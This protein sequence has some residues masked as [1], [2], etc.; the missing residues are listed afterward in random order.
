L[1]TAVANLAKAAAP[2]A[3]P[4]LAAPAEGPSFLNGWGA[5][6]AAICVSDLQYEDSDADECAKY[7]DISSD[8]DDNSDEN[9]NYWVT[10]PDGTVTPLTEHIVASDEATVAPAV[11]LVAQTYAEG[12]ESSLSDEESSDEEVVAQAQVQVPLPD[13]SSSDE[14]ADD[15]DYI[16]DQN[17][18]DAKLD[19]LDLQ[20][21]VKQGKRNMGTVELPL[22][23]CSDTGT[24]DVDNSFSMG[25]AEQGWKSLCSSDVFIVDT[26]AGEFV[27]P[28]KSDFVEGSLVDAV[29]QQMITAGNERHRVAQLGRMR[30]KCAV[31]GHMIDSKDQY[32][33]WVPTSKF[34]LGSMGKLKDIGFGLSIGI[35]ATDFLF[36]ISNGDRIPV[37][38]CF[39]VF[40]LRAEQSDRAAIGA[41]LTGRFAEQSA[42]GASLKAEPTKAQS[43][44]GEKGSRGLLAAK[45]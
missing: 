33:W 42:W 13:V 10:Y 28:H 27:S 8:D 1:K 2:A 31:T 16:E 23:V 41:Y 17:I 25:T 32:G 29:G 44:D 18:E 43:T 11:A 7:E 3:T 4:A 37:Q 14:D 45:V 21:I 30:V 39:G 19:C 20:Q 26:G 24:S 15:E 38:R 40:V 6:G 12:N 34:R 5:C 35:E 9:E 36:N 22:K